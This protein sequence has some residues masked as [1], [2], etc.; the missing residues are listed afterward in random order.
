MY[1]YFDQLNEDIISIT[2]IITVG[3]NPF[4]LAIMGSAGL[5]TLSRS[6]LVDFTPIIGLV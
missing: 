6:R 5:R 3:D 4:T 1:M 2:I